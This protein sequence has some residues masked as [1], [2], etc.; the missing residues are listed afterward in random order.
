MHFYQGNPT[1][2]LYDFPLVLQCFGG[3]EVTT[4]GAR[5]LGQSFLKLGASEKT[6]E[7]GVDVADFESP[8]GENYVSH[9]SKTKV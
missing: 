5:S 1:V 3:S 7:L 2:N 4:N 8:N 9:A 6:A